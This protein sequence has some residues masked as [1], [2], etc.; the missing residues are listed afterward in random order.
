MVASAD[1]S[2]NFEKNVRLIHQITTNKID[3]F[4]AFHKTTKNWKVCFPR[5]PLIATKFGGQG[6]KSQQSLF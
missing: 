4:G 6:F 2:S 3:Y 1:V 5:V